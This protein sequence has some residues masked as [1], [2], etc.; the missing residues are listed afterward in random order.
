MR[1]VAVS[2]LHGHLPEIPPCDLLIVAGA[3]IGYLDSGRLGIEPAVAL[4]LITPVAIDLHLGRRSVPSISSL[5]HDRR[6]CQ[7]M[8]RPAVERGC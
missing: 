4:D 8:P 6:F 1:I 5:R 7:L 3:I 2:D